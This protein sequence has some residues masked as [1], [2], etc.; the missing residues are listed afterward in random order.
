MNHSNYKLYDYSNY[1]HY[2]NQDLIM[3]LF[4]IKCKNKYLKK[5]V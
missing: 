5:D 3:S 4:K 2:Y 1:K